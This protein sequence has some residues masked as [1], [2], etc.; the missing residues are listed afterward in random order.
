MTRWIGNK[1]T[2]YIYIYIYTAGLARFL[3]Q[4]AAK[5]RRS[6]ENTSSATA[7]QELA[8]WSSL[9]GD[10]LKTILDLLPW[11]SHPRFAAVCRHW[12]SVVAP[13]YPAWLTPV[14]LN[15]AADIG[16]ANLRY[17]SPYHHKIFEEASFNLQTPNAKICSA[18]GRHLTVCQ[19]ADQ[20]ITVAH[21]DL[22][23]GV[24]CDLFP[25]HRTHFDFVI[26]DGERRRMYGVNNAFPISQV[27][28]AIQDADSGGWYPW[29]FS[30]FRV[31]KPTLDASPMTN[32]VR[33]RGLLYMLGVD[34]RLAV[35]D[36]NRH[37]E[38][39]RLLDKPQGFGG[40]D[41][42]F[43]SYLFE[44]DEGELMAVLM[45]CCRGTPVHVLKLNEQEMQSRWTAA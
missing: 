7:T 43:F 26:Y 27:A 6:M 29:K 19:R 3:T 10:L 18:S 36:D 35:Y 39:L 30:E 34:G 20:E 42:D 45:G 5:R 21:I 16:S 23:T 40:F 22:V 1:S 13:F 15:A 8:G 37:E 25:L 28:R 44:S 32:L 14:L 4:A 9:P 24:I 11:S 17:Y 31:D 41:D 38:G 12:R 33:H 2:I